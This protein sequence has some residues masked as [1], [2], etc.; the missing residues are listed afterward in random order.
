M[1]LLPPCN[2]SLLLHIKHSNY[3]AKIW[4]SSLTSWLD[5]EEIS[6][7]GWLANGSTYWVDDIVPQEIE[8][9]LCDPK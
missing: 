1:A 3:V 8:E 9:M 6:E 2:F 4:R 5:A 7:N